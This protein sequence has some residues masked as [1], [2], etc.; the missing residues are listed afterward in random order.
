MQAIGATPVFRNG[1][2][3][4]DILRVIHIPNI[5]GAIDPEHFI[6]QRVGKAPGFARGETRLVESPPKV[7]VSAVRREIAGKLTA[8]AR[9]VNDQGG[10]Y[11][12]QLALSFLTAPDEVASRAGAIRDFI[13]S[14]QPFALVSSYVAGCEDEIGPYLEANEVPVIGPICLYAG[15]EPLEHRHVFHILSGLAGQGKAL[16]RFAIRRP[17]IGHRAVLVSRDGDEEV[18]AVIESVGKLLVAAGWSAPREIA[19]KDS[20]K[21][22]WGDLLSAALLWQR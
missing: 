20:S 19:V 22:D 12:R 4:C 3:R 9:Q 17:E 15:G 14:A 11:G 6:E 10:L 2:G 16:A 8:Y 5:R 18:R 21:P 13:E 7:N 1:K